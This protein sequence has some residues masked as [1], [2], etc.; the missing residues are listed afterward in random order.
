MVWPV[1]NE[2]SCARP[3]IPA[4]WFSYRNCAWALSHSQKAKANNKFYGL[5]LTCLPAHG[6]G[7]GGWEGEKM[8]LQGQL[9]G[10]AGWTGKH[11]PDGRSRQR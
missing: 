8:S 5:E 6:R 3:V 2:L 1:S 11:E 4:P 7:G 10:G 9:Q